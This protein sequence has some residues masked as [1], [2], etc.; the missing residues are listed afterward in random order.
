MP[1]VANKSTDFVN[2]FPCFDTRLEAVNMGIVK[3]LSGV[4][5]VA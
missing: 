3:A 2:L 5:Q 1:E 4:A